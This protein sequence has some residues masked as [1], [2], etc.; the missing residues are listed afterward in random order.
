M[1]HGM[2]FFVRLP[3]LPMRAC[4]MWPPLATVCATATASCGTS[5]LKTASFATVP[6]MGRTSA[7]LAPKIRFIVSSARVS[8]SSTKRVPS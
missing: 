4:E 7:K 1:G 5:L 8:I 6:A 3:R 2:M